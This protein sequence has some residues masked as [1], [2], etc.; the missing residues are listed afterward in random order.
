MNDPEFCYADAFQETVKTEDQP[1]SD[2]GDSGLS[3]ST[4]GDSGSGSWLSLGWGLGLLWVT[5]VSARVPVVCTRTTSKECIAEAR[6]RSPI[7][8]AEEA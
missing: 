8:I 1:I 6:A 5:R 3:G 4:V 2:F 7:C